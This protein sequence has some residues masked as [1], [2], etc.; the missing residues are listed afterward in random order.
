MQYLSSA[1]IYKP[2]T[3]FK[4][5]EFSRWEKHKLTKAPNVWSELV[6]DR[7]FL[8]ILYLKSP[9]YENKQ[10]AKLKVKMK[11]TGRPTQIDPDKVNK[12]IFVTLAVFG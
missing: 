12:G 11:V 5:S 3:A 8:W 1:L 10:R 4:I 6:F 9:G 7:Q 2:N